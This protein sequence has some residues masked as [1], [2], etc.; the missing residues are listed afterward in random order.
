M[1]IREY[2]KSTEKFLKNKLAII[3]QTRHNHIYMLFLV[4]E[5]Y[6]Q[7]LVFAHV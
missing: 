5:L 2:L 7:I 6:A 1:F 3:L 4:C